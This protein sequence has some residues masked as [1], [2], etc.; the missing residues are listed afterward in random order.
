VLRLVG[1]DL[2]DALQ[3]RDLAQE[4]TR[5]PRVPGEQGL[6]LGGQA[7]ARRRPRHQFVGEGDAADLAEQGRDL[8]LPDPREADLPG[9][10]ADQRAAA[11]RPA[12]RRRADHLEDL[13]ERLHRA[14]QGLLQQFPLGGDQAVLPHGGP[15][16]PRQALPGTRLGE[17]PEDAAL[18][19]RVD[20]DPLVR[21]PGQQQ[22]DGV[23]E[24]QAD[25]GEQ[26]DAVPP[27]HV[28]VGDDGGEGAFR[29]QQQEGG[30]G[31][32]GRPDVVPGEAGAELVR[33]QGEHP[34][35]VVNEQDFRRH[36]VPSPP[37]FRRPAR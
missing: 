10:Q 8:Q 20:R 14:P 29:L 25:L 23:G 34:R 35:L 4:L 11:R 36:G 18:V 3:P 33:E 28:V 22:A 27:G 30:V 19:H 13:G 15:D 37:T 6:L 5:D 26:L 32:L 12:E 31:V 17:E 16:G 7:E 2:Q 9:H 24:A 21:V 1:D